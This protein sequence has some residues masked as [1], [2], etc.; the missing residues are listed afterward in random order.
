MCRLPSIGAPASR[1]SHGDSL[2]G[3]RACTRTLVAWAEEGLDAHSAMVCATRSVQVIGPTSSGCDVIL[4]IPRF[5]YQTPTQQ[6]DALP[7]WP[8]VP[9]ILLAL[10][11]ESP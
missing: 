6:L 3:T 1:S 9:R 5:V 7:L 11:W 8:L 10:A 4:R 2:F